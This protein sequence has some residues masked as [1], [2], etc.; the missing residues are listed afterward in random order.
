MTTC[1]HAKIL[2]S[3]FNQMIKLR[4]LTPHSPTS[5]FLI[6][7][8]LWDKESK[9][10][11]RPMS[12]MLTFDR[13]VYKHSPF[14]QLCHTF[15]VFIEINCLKY[16]L[17]LLVHSWK[18]DLNLTIFLPFITCKFWG[19]VLNILV[20]PSGVLMHVNFACKIILMGLAMCCMLWA[21][22]IFCPKGYSLDARH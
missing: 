14:R 4:Y 18:Y 10:P 17:L 3:I 11:C 7:C 21:Q 1:L 22:Y 9:S 13:S 5:H 15:V 12:L 20:Y 19:T 8:G 6:H 16:K 2:S